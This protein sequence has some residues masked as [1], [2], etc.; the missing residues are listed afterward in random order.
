MSLYLIRHASAG[1][2]G[3]GAADLDRALDGSGNIRAQ[4]IAQILGSNSVEA[5]YSSPA[6]RCVETVQPLADSL[7]LAVEIH[8]ELQEGASGHTLVATLSRLATA[9]GTAVLCSHGDLIPSTIGQLGAS[10]VPL[11]GNGCAK[12]S[13]WAL[14][15]DDGKITEGRYL[16]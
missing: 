6:R 13:I 8:D 5:I 3:S 9:G 12:G 11:A 14:Q 7:G 2:R 1:K 15:V 16:S 4:T 10:G